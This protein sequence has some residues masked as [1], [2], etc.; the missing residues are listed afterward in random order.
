[1]VSNDDAKDISLVVVGE[2][3]SV[4]CPVLLAI[5]QFNTRYIAELAYELPMH[6]M[7]EMVRV[8]SSIV[9]G[10]PQG[11]EMLIEI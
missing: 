6:P 9:F 8:P 5:I 1:M 2:S 11:S 4:S 10:R 7:H 3:T